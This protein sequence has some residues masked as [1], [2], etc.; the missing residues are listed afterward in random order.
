LDSFHSDFGRKEWDT[1]KPGKMKIYIDVHPQ[2]SEQTFQTIETFHA[3]ASAQ[4]VEL[5]INRTA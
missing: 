2:S 3:K 1:P 5:V 4:G